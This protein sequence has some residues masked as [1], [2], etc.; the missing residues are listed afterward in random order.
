MSLIDFLTHYETIE[1]CHLTPD[2]IYSQMTGVKSSHPWNMIQHDGAW[3]K[4]QTAGG[5]RQHYLETYAS[6][7]QFHITLT[8]PDPL[9]GDNR[10]TLIV[11][12]MKKNIRKLNYHDLYNLYIGFDIYEVKNGNK[13]LTKNY[14]KDNDIFFSLKNRRNENLKF[15]TRPRDF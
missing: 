9:L 6:N 3:I 10:C 15:E 2:I 7:P 5:C 12:L 11:G 4:G 14:F 13:K 8:D 1:I